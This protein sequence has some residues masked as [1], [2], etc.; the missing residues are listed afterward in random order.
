MEDLTKDFA[1][2]QQQL[3]LAVAKF[4]LSQKSVE[5]LTAAQK[6]LNSR[7]SS[8]AAMYSDLQHHLVETQAV[9][10]TALDECAR[11]YE[12]EK[13]KIRSEL[14]QASAQID[15][16]REDIER[17]RSTVVTLEAALSDAGEAMNS[18]ESRYHAGGQM[19]L[20]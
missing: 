16:A 1:D 2:V 4:D 11:G 7:L 3:A 8:S 14:A 6:T 17:L 20:R 15:S 5:D 13:M 10:K 19:V 18:F 9:S 12:D